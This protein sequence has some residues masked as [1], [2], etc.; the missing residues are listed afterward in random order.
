MQVELTSLENAIEFVKGGIAALKSQ[1]RRLKNDETTSSN[2]LTMK[3]QGI[4][5]AAVSGG[6]KNYEVCMYARAYTVCLFVHTVCTYVTYICAQAQVKRRGTN[7]EFPLPQV[8]FT[9]KYRDHYPHFSK[10]TAELK[11]QMAALVSLL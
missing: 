5:D 7:G 10:L 4:L 8:F 11:E 2:Q 6:L 9:D 1:I 3:L